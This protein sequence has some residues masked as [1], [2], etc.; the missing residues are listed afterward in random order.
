MCTDGMSYWSVCQQHI[1]KLCAVCAVCKDWGV[2]DT[3]WFWLMSRDAAE[4]ARLSTSFPEQLCSALYLQSHFVMQYTVVHVLKWLPKQIKM[5]DK[6]A[7]R[8]NGQ[9]ASSGLREWWRNRQ[10]AADIDCKSRKLK[11]KETGQDAAVFVSSHQPQM[12]LIA[13]FLFPQDNEC[14][15]CPLG[16]H[17][18]L[19]L[20]LCSPHH[21]II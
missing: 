6:N 11:F 13:V 15:S 4:V 5:V 21:D 3:L 1:V 2:C 7:T 18:G 12:P 16:S 17:L 14:W 20:I 8:A 10:T 9:M 19:W